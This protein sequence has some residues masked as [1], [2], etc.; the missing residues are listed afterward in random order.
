MFQSSRM[1]C[2]PE[3]VGFEWCYGSTGRLYS[4]DKNAEATVDIFRGKKS[5]P[6]TLILKL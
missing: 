4:G 1:E 2:C 6:S 3:G 5:D